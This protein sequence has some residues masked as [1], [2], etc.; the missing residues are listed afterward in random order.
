M[1]YIYL[2]SPNLDYWI[3]KRS[4]IADQIPI[5]ITHNLTEWLEHPKESRISLHEEVTFSP[6]NIKLVQLLA[7]NSSLVLIFM[8]ELI[9]DEWC[10]IFDQSNVVF[11][12]AGQL[13]YRPP[14]SATVYRHNY[15]FWSTVDFHRLV[16]RVLNG[17][18]RTLPKS[19]DFDILLGRKKRHRD[20][21][22][23]TVDR[24]NS[25]VTYF[26]DDGGKDL[27]NCEKDYFQW[28]WEILNGTAVRST[29]DTVSVRDTLVSLSQIVPIKIYNQTA[30]SLVCESQFENRWSFFTE[31]IIKPMLA[32]RVFIVCSGRY[33]LRNLREWGFKTFDGIVDESYDKEPDLERRVSMIS[34]SMRNLALQD[35]QE[36]Y[37]Q[38]QP[39]LDHNYNLLMSTPW[40]QIMAD[41]ISAVITKQCEKL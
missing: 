30:Y 38:A 9:N 29:A 3:K 10:R 32:Q 4:G 16:P 33:F 26:N 35:Q 21:I 14:K 23:E 22:W 28:P 31:K 37:A 27:V 13:N 25:I 20:L 34:T 15:F 7:D 17:L 36:V 8:P 18:D 24:S 39:I 11:F 12:I 6:E 19:Q 41:D 40:L 5:T 1:H 2:N